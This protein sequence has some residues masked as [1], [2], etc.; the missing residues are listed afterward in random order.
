VREFPDAEAGESVSRLRSWYADRRG[1]RAAPVSAP[2]NSH[3]A[4]LERL[5][6]LRHRGDLTDAEYQA[7][8]TA[9]LGRSKQHV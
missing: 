7:Q 4:D 8:K 6:A 5:A 1:A 2:D 3:I 9:I